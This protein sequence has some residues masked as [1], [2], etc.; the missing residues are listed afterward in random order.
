MIKFNLLP[1]QE[2]KEVEL[3]RFNQFIIFLTGCFLILLIVFIGLLL[4]T[5]FYLSTLVD[6]QNKL[7]KLE[8]GDIKTERLTNIEQRISR[9]NQMVERVFSYQKETILVT[10]ILEELSK[11]VPSG[12]YLTDFSYQKATE[13]IRISGRA[14]E[15]DAILLFQQ[16]LNEDPLFVNLEA[17]LSN[18]LKQKNIDF[19]FG[20]K[21]KVSSEEAQ[22]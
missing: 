14:N 22:K 2:K 13:Q 3:A 1:P 12:I 7:I 8:Q 20:L 17:P 19:N 16:K 9:T 11:I 18:L 4:T 15:R 10:P 6:A 21:I 5:Y